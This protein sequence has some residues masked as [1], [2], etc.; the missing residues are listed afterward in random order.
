MGESYKLYLRDPVI[1]QQKHVNAPKKESN[2]VMQLFGS[3]RIVLP[4]TVP[5]DNEM[6]EY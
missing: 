4:N 1:L 3:S 5:V 2:K 6:G